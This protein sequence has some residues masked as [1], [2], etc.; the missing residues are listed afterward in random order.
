MNTKSKCD[1][2]KLMF[3]G[4]NFIGDGKGKKVVI[5]AIS[6]DES[7][8]TVEGYIVY[9]DDTAV[10]PIGYVGYAWTGFMDYDGEVVL[11]NK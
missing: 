10:W 2:P 9:S 4:G 5:L 3:N 11:K 6:A 7:D 8:N 1:F